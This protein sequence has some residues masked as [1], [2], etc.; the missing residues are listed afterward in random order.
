MWFAVCFTHTAWSLLAVFTAGHTKYQ[1]WEMQGMDIDEEEEDN[2]NDQEE[3][4]EEEEEGEVCEEGDP[5]A[6]H[7]RPTFTEF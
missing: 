4:V 1:A 2:E 7:S 6:G 3:E 5:L